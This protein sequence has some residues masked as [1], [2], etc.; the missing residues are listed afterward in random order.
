MNSPIVAKEIMATKLVTLSP[1]MDVFDAIGLLLKHRISGAPV[2]DSDWNLLGIFSEKDSMRVLL[3][4]AY[5]QIPTTQL[6]AFMDTDVRTINEET[7]LLTI[8]QIFRTTPY[9]RL[10]V[11]RDDKLVGQVSRRDVLQAAHQLQAVAPDRE[12]ALLYLSSLIDR[13]DAPIA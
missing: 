11:L 4:A 10:P 9:R 5:D 7:D 12:T 13:N 3:E 8:A 6:F 1:E 2:I